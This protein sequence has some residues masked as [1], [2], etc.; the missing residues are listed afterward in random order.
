[1]SKT[2]RFSKG[3]ISPTELACLRI[4]AER[5]DDDEGNCYYFR[6]IAKE[7]K[8]EIPLVRKAVRSLARKGL[9]EYMRGLFDQDGMVAGSG[10]SC[11]AA[12]AEVVKEF[13]SEDPQNNHNP[14]F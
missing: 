5:Y 6:S 11:T 8:L 12:G 14:L 4:L 10:Y 2:I 7:T 3:T 1:M 13:E 9:A